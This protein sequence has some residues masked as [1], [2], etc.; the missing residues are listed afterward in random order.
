MAPTSSWSTPSAASPAPYLQPILRLEPRTVLVL[1]LRFRRQLVGIL[2]LGD[3][4]G[5]VAGRDEQLQVRRLA[6]Q[7]AVALANAQM[8]EQVRSLAY[9]DSLTGLPN[10]L[11]LQGAPGLGAGAGAA[12]REARRRVLHRSR[13]L[14]PHQ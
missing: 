13:P 10:R 14:Q 2:A 4:T 1:P 11:S 3:R 7:V 8:L 6:D 9:Y 12:Q 5:T